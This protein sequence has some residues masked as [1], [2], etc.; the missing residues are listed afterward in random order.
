MSYLADGIVIA[1]G[2]TIIIVEYNRGEAK[3]KIKAE[4][5]AIAEACTKAAVEARFA[6]IER[7]ITDVEEALPLKIQVISLHL[8]YIIQNVHLIIHYNVICRGSLNS[9][10]FR[11]KMPEFALFNSVTYGT[12][13]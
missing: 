5:T 13:S 7:G 6:A 9:L 2:A 3:N 4:K 8:L 10:N 1:L 11:M 12:F